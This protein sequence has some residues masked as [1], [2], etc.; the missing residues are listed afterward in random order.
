M[1][2]VRRGNEMTADRGLG[3]KLTSVKKGVYFETPL[4]K[5]DGHEK[6]FV[7]RLPSTGLDARR[8]D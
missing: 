3:R 2:R 6:H 7:D 8:T 4:L 1:A 5:G